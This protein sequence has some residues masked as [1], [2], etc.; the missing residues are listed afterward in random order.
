MAW[1]RKNIGRSHQG[2]RIVLGLGVA[3]VGLTVLS[4]P[5]AWLLAAAGLVFALTGA[6]GYC[7]ACA[8]AG[9]GSEGRS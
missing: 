1:L 2:V 7:P 9:I 8:I 3:A 4:G 5:G 6:V